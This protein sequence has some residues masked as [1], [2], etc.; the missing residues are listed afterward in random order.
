LLGYG[1]QVGIRVAIALAQI[2]EFS[3][4]L[5]TVGDQLN[6]L[7]Q[8]ATNLIV[9][10]SIISLALNPLLYRAIGRAR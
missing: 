3:L 5:A 7:P 10:A 1:A 6:I 4:I 2:G 9:A 8:G